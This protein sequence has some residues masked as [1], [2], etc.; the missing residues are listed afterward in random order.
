MQETAL[1]RDMPVTD[2]TGVRAVSRGR[3]KTQKFE[4]VSKNQSCQTTPKHMIAAYGPF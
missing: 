3:V 2:E 1:G 4:P